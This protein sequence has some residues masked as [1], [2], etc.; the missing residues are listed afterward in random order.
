MLKV[1]NNYEIAISVKDNLIQY[2]I[3]NITIVRYLLDLYE[4]T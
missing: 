2:C 4:P 3:Q 1:S